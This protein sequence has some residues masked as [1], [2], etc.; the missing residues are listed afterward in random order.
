M[1]RCSLRSLRAWA[2][3]EAK[4]LAGV[5]LAGFRTKLGV[6][7]EMALEMPSP[8]VTMTGD[9]DVLVNSSECFDGCLTDLDDDSGVA[10]A[11]LR[12]E[13]SLL[14]EGVDCLLFDGG[15]A[16]VLRKSIMEMPSSSPSSFTSSGSSDKKSIKDIDLSF[17][18]LAMARVRR[19]GKLDCG[20]H[21]K[22][23]RKKKK[24]K[25]SDALL[26][27]SPSSTPRCLH[28]C[29]QR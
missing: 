10:R 17:A 13:L 26:V 20:L 29:V 22:K 25:K 21:P 6:D 12:L 4:G 7:A 1:E 3:S 23:K 15:G 16:E 5:D 27:A 28:L 19:T 14:F 24:K 18:F 9:E 2:F 11:G 8:C